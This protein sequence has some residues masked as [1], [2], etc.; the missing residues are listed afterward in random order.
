MILF[1][2][3]RS[4][5][6]A[7][8]FSFA[9]PMLLMSGSLASGWLLTCIPGLEFVGQI[10]SDILLNFLDAFGSGC[11]FQGMFTICIAC[12]FVGALFDLYVFYSFQTQKETR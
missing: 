9:A 4:V 3:F 5:S 11:A 12:G 2:L 8:V 6:I 10:P 7:I 1:K